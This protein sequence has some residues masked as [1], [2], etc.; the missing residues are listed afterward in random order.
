MR[1]GFVHL[2]EPSIN[3]RKVL[4]KWFEQEVKP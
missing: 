2:A 4:D 1:F 3:Y